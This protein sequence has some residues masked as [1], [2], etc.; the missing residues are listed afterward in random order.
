MKQRELVWAAPA[1]AEFDE[2]V[3][4][5]RAQDP[6]TAD[7]VAARIDERIGSLVAHPRIGRLGR[8]RGTRE[9]VVSPFVVAY[10]VTDDLIVILAV[11]RGRRR[12]PRSFSARRR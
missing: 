4:Y 7:R 12:W 8:V 2:L 9:L 1:L 11:L 6:A 5:L 10:E 3:A